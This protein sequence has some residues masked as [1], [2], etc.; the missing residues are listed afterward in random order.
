MLQHPGLCDDVCVLFKLISVLQLAMRRKLCSF[1]RLYLPN[2]GALYT[3][4][5]P[6]TQ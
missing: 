4:A 1:Y 5:A 3:I 2:C 6:E